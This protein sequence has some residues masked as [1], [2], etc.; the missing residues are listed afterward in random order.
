MI[1]CLIFM[2]RRID[3]EGIVTSYLDFVTCV[4]TFYKKCFLK[5]LE[6]GKTIL[7]LNPFISYVFKR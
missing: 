7:Y 3:L 6:I 5:L 4:L 1:V 2:V